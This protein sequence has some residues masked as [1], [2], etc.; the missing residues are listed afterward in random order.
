MD[1]SSERYKRLI[2]NPK[3]ERRVTRLWY[4]A[5]QAHNLRVMSQLPIGLISKT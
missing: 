1:R 2:N 3:F 5:L 4:K